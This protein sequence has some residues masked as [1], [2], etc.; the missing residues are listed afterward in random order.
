MSTNFTTLSGPTMGTRF[1]AVFPKEAPHDSKSLLN[2]LQKSMDSVDQQM[3]PWIGSSVV[4]A[5]NAADVNEWVHI[6]FHTANV[7][8]KALEIEAAS[9]GAFSIFVGEAVRHYGFSNRPRSVGAAL[10]ANSHG[11]LII[12]NDRLRKSETTQIDLCGI[13]KG[14]G[15]DLLAETMQ[16]HGIGNFLVSIDGELRCQGKP[17]DQSN[18]QIGL[19]VPDPEKRRTACTLPCENLALATSGGYRHFTK[20]KHGIIT[21]TIDPKTNRS[22]ADITTSVTVAAKDCCTAEAWAT[23]LLV[24]PDDQVMET[25]AANNLNALF[26]KQIQGETM[27]SAYGAFADQQI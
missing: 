12:E 22:L 17:D 24:M 2:D 9:R 26:L 27:V 4:N 1:S 5:I 7:I 21:H 6:P 20:T 16:Q 3:S 23:A 15:V 25:V 10:S 11:T 8:T 19:E 13:A 14:Y 18:W